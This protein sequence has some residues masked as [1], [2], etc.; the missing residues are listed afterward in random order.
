MLDSLEKLD[1]DLLLKIN[2]WHTPFLDTFMWYMSESWHTVFIILVVAYIFYKKFSLKKAIEFVLGCAIVFACTDLSSN[3]VKHGIQRYRPTHNLEIKHQIHIVNNYSGGKFGFF[4]SHSANL[5]GI[6]TF[7]FLCI[8]WIHTK[9]KLL[10]YIYP[11]LVV[12]SRMYMGVHYP[13][14]I[15]G[16]IIDGVF[17]GMLVFYIINKYFLKLNVQQA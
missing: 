15:I 13:S 11:L 4:S 6:I 2:S 12:Y 14:D 16:G 7:I 3:V 1:R 10:F 17:F 5:F 8:N 9:Y